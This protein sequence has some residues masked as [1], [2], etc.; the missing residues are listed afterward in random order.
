MFGRNTVGHKILHQFGFILGIAKSAEDDFGYDILFADIELFLESFT[1]I[2]KSEQSVKYGCTSV[3]LCNNASAMRNLLNSLVLEERFNEEF[4]TFIQGKKF[5]NNTDATC[6][7]STDMPFTCAIP[8]LHSCQ[9]CIV[10]V[11]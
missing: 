11:Y 6:F 8:T 2:L 9:R 1:R 10:D 5:D 3:N 7:R 4:L